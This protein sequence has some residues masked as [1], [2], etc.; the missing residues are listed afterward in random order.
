MTMVM[1]LVPH[2]FP[3]QLNLVNFR[4]SVIFRRRVVAMAVSMV[5]EE[6]HQRACED[7]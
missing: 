6:M 3:A 2:D 7:D 1:M 5:H 4:F